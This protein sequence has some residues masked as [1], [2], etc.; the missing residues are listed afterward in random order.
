MVSAGQAN[1]QQAPRAQQ[2]VCQAAVAAGVEPNAAMKLAI[3]NNAIAEGDFQR[4][5]EVPIELTDS[6]KTQ[7]NNEWRT[8]TSSGFTLT[9]WETYSIERW[10]P[11]INTPDLHTPTCT[12]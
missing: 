6:E 11:R 4:N 3:L 1:L 2:L 5:L 7:Y 12:P 9:W 10:K 8:Y